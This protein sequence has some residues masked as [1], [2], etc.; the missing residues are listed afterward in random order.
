MNE[1][2]GSVLFVKEIEGSPISGSINF[3]SQPGY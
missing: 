1:R 2:L 3:S